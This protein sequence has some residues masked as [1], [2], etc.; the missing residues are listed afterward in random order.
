MSEEVITPSPKCFSAPFNSK[1]AE[2]PEGMSKSEWKRQQKAKLFEEQKKEW[3]QKK[4]E[5]HKKLKA[6]RKRQQEELIASGAIEAPVAVYKP[7]LKKV[8]AQVII[9]CAFDDLMTD[10][11]RI[12][13]GSQILRVYS[14][15]KRGPLTVNMML[16][17]FNKKLAHRFNTNMQGQHLQWKNVKIL[18][19]DYQIPGND[20]ANWVYLS[21]DS[22]NVLNELDENMTY[23]IGGIVDKGRYKNLCKDKADAQNIKTGRLPIEKYIQLAGRKVLTTNHV[24]E[25]LLKWFEFKDWKAAF[26]A[27]LPQRKIIKHKDEEEEEEEAKEEEAIKEKEEEEEEEEEEEKIITES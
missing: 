24:F 17:S 1:T 25:L 4:K 27:V 18:E 21:S 16:S 20:N 19:D 15:N 11:E 22:S 26:D 10:K 9:D 14:D 6:E 13:L 3:T 23:V 7:P 12:S 2:I 8:N 5:K